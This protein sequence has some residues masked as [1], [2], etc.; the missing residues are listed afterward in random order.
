MNEGEQLDHYRTMDSLANFLDNKFG[1]YEAS[2]D[3]DAQA[4]KSGFVVVGE[5]ICYCSG[6]LQAYG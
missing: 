5:K 3:M 4:Y 2:Q 6:H 1:E